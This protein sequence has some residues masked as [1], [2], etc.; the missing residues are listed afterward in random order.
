MYIAWKALKINKILLKLIR[1]NEVEKQLR[2]LDKQI[3]LII[4]SIPLNAKF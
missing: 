1:S 2:R 4:M 3:Q